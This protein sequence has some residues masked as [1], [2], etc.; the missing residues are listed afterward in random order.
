MPGK[1]Q[2]AVTTPANSRSGDRFILQAIDASHGCPVLETM[3]WVNDLKMLRAILGDEAAEDTDLRHIYRLEPA[4]LNAITQYFDVAFDFDGRECW[5]GRAHSIGNVPYLVHTGYELALMLDGRKPFA[6]FSIEYP[7]EPGDFPEGDLF[8][9][10]VQSGLLIKR[11]MDNEPFEKPVRVSNGR[12]YLGVRQV[13]YARRGQEWRI[14]AYMLLWKQLEHG[15]W[16]ETLERLDGSILGYT[17]QQNDWWHARRR[18]DHASPTYSDRTAYI[19]IDADELAWIR[20]IG[21][22]AF[23]PE[24][25]GPGLEL[26]MHLPRP[27]PA[28]L[29]AWLTA[30]GAA[31]IVRVGVPRSFLA[32]RDFGHRDGARSYLIKPEDVLVLNRALTSSIEVAAERARSESGH[33]AP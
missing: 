9:P 8:E 10:Y 11:V 21:E 16:N 13:F 22:R 29:Q 24:R 6:R 23:K 15:P 3:I 7:V 18:R 19:A 30:L 4:Q 28:V 32:G 27:E 12:V 31:A 25:S 26:V 14:D 33:A 5:L 2:N 1:N 20:T 17:D